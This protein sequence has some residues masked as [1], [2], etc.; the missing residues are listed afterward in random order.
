MGE[1]KKTKYSKLDLEM[2]LYFQSSGK[3]LISI[4]ANSVLPTAF[5]GDVCKLTTCIHAL[6]QII[7][8][9]HSRSYKFNS[10]NIRN[11]IL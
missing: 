7:V 10:N 2:C 4:N 5:P 9:I 6:I 3:T 8:H 1:F 11:I